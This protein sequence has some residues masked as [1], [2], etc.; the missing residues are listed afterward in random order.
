MAKG[1]TATEVEKAKADPAKRREI[2]DGKGLYLVVQPTGAKQ[3]AFRYRRPGDGKPAKLSLG[4]VAKPGEEPIAEGENKRLTLALARAHAAALR[5]KLDAGND[6][7]EEREVQKAAKVTAQRIRSETTFEIVAVQF[8]KQARRKTKASSWMEAARLLG[9]RPDADKPGELKRREPPELAEGKRAPF[10]GVAHHWEGRP[11]ADITK[12]DVADLLETIADGGAPYS[13]IQVHAHLSGLFRWLVAREVLAVS[14]VAG[15]EKAATAVAREHV[16]RDWELALV[17]RGTALIGE[18]FGPFV[19]TLILTGQRR[20]EVA[21]MRWSELD[22]EGRVWT[23]PGE[24]AKNGQEHIVP[25]SAEA[26]AVLSGVERIGGKPDFVFTSGSLSGAPLAPVSGFSRAKTRLD[27]AILSLVRADA[28]KAGIPAEEVEPPKDWRFHDLRRTM[29][30]GLQ[31]LKHPLQVTES[32]LNHR[33][34]SIR[35]VAAVYHRHDFLAEKAEALS[36]WG[37]HVASL[38]APPSEPAAEPGNVVPMKKAAR[39]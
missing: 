2:P 18:P 38:T 20:D 39:A 1:L 34:G 3:W 28:E 11:V 22:F 9:F 21:K 32:L 12:S 6:P 29:A 5:V 4:K 23:L 31:R 35:G 30:T 33:S 25:L 14:P 26:V 7:A 8:L 13:S 17:W 24:R 15:V 19:K 10:L 36:D 27:A 37:A 16:L